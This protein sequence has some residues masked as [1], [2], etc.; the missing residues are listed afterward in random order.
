MEQIIKM[1][2]DVCARRISK[3]IELLELE[4]VEKEKISKEAEELIK[5]VIR[6]FGASNKEKGDYRISNIMLEK[7]H[8]TCN[9]LCTVG[10]EKYKYEVQ[11]YKGYIELINLPYISKA[12]DRINHQKYDAKVLYETMNIIN[13]IQNYHI[14][15][16][17]AG[18][19]KN[20]EECAE[21]VTFGIL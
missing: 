4:E 3:G 14:S 15:S 19:Y 5:L 1:A 9:I 20:S 7:S 2:E 10:F 13:E 18:E 12:I 17:S 6:L 16:W 11:E 8:Q 21:T